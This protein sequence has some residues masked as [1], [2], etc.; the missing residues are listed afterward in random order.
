MIDAGH[1]EIVPGP[2]PVIRLVQEAWRGRDLLW[3]LVLRDLRLRYRQTR[4]GLVW[5]IGQ[6]LISAAL[7]AFV[8][9]RVAHLTSEG[10]PYILFAFT[11]IMGW[12]FFSAVLVKA[13][14][15]LQ[16]NSPFVARVYTPRLLL[17]M[18]GA[19]VAGMDLLV[20]FGV[21]LILLLSMGRPPT[22]SWLTLPIWCSLLLLLSLGLGLL[23]AALSVVRRDLLQVVPL[24]LQVAFYVCPVAY[25][26]SM[27]PIRLRGL[28]GANPLA[29]LLDGI[30]AAVLGTH[31]PSAGR[32][33][34]ATVLAVVTAGTGLAV[35]VRR[36][37]GF[38][39]AI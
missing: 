27:V 28:Y 7:I 2:T 16:A 17:P 12:T 29:T 33:A 34:I 23:V 14:G 11:G 24:S 5:V 25:G 38:A 21:L 30:R 22:Y 10:V 35:F 37:P 8:F 31:L 4:L 3:L 1:L 26:T 19:F 9:S 13:G 39:D 6:A 18:V 32:V 20:N 36:E 15:G